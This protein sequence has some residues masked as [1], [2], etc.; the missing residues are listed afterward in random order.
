VVGTDVYTSRK[1][2]GTSTYGSCG[3]GYGYLHVYR[4]TDEGKK[5]EFLHRMRTVSLLLP[6]IISLSSL[7]L[8]LSLSSSLASSRSR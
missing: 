6:Q 7:S 5:L 2:G 1:G 8:S 4:L 3:R